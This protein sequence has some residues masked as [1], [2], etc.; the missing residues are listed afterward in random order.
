M[1]ACHQGSIAAMAL[2]R[3]GDLLATASEKGTLVR[4]WRISDYK[5]TCPCFFRRGSD[6]AEISDLVF[7]RDSAMIAVSSD[8]PTIHVF[9]IDIKNSDNHVNVDEEEEKD[10]EAKT[11]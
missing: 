2:N 4:I 3:T 11:G 8:K 5:A 7:S 1:F 9:K 10:P 6:K